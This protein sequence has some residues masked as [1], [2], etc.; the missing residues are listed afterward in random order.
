MTINRSLIMKKNTSVLIVIAF[1]SVFLFTFAG[2]C[3]A[4]EASKDEVTKVEDI[5]ESNAIDE[6]DSLLEEVDNL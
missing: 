2:K 6:A 4:P 5:T 3:G 1:I